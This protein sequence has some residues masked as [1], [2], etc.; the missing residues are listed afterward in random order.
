MKKK[1]SLSLAGL[2]LFALPLFCQLSFLALIDYQLLLAKASV[3]HQLE[4]EE[5]SKRINKHLALA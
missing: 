5:C 3:K 4:A 1:R 2:V